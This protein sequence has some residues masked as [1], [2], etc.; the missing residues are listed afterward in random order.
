MVKSRL[1]ASVRGLRY[2]SRFGLA[3]SSANG[4]GHAKRD[5]D[6]AGNM[7]Q[8]PGS[9]M[10]IIGSGISGL[11]AAYMLAPY[12]KITVYEKN[13]Y[14]GGHA[15]TV[16]VATPQG[17]VPVDTGFIVFNDRTYPL[18]TSLFAHL[19]VPVEKSDMSFGASI[20]NGWLEYGTKGL[21][22]LFARKSNL[23][24]PRFWRMAADILRF[25]AGARRYLESDASLTLGECLDELGTG[26]WFRD[27]YLLAM[28]GAIWSTPVSGMLEFPACTF[29]RF[30]DNHGLLTIGD[31]PQWYTVRGGS[32]EYVRR[33]SA[34]F[35]GRIL[36]GC[37][38]TAVIRKTDHV[39]VHDEKG[40]IL[41]YDDVIFACHADQVLR[42][43]KNPTKDEQSVLS[44]LRYRSG[45][46]VLHSD[47]QFMPKRKSAWASWVYL[48]EEAKDD[49]QH[50]CLSYWMNNLQPLRTGMPVI[51]TLNPSREPDGNLVHDE[52]RF[53][54][55][56]FDRA[57][58]RAQ[59]RIDDIQGKDRLWFCGAYQ[60]YGFH[61]DGLRSA[62][63]MAGKT[64]VK[65]SWK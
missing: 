10:A 28:G 62:V 29:I 52:C 11:G 21:H 63:D 22:N 58:I 65:P 6:S 1:K 19:N 46:M 49:S 59:G 23:V 27:Y 50:M 16:D 31:H 4:N 54:H 25:N 30:F 17:T 7:M 5:G 51:V 39:L 32:R 53:E 18:L 40:R 15:R 13:D 24:N 33:L 20:R 42:L 12:H 26:E 61:E 8:K 60:R 9:N 3:G 37:G 56:V 44:D 2:G 47:T 36:T 34:G 41:K 43:V 64:G 48:S 14:A 38:V 35:S 45:R 55:P 57:A